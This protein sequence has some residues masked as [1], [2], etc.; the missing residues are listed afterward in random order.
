MTTA[1][2]EYRLNVR[3]AGKAYSLDFRQAFYFGYVQVRTG[4]FREASPIFE[5]LM[6]SGAGGSLATIM[7]AYCKAALKDYAADS[8]L[9]KSLSKETSKQEEVLEEG[10]VKCEG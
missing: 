7:L 10:N 1:M 5:A 9:L 3:A 6:R 4:K 8:E 2:R